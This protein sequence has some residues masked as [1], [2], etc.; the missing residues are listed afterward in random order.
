MQEIKKE[1]GIFTSNIETGQSAEEVYQEWLENKDSP[2]ARPLT[3]TEIL[4]EQILTMQ[5]VLNFI[6]INY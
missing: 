2:P 3:E 1:H 4:Q 5:D 6:I